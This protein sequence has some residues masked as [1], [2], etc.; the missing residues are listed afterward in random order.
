MCLHFESW[1]K[2]IDVSPSQTR[3]CYEILSQKHPR[4]TRT[5]G[6]VHCVLVNVVTLSGS[7]I[8][9]ETHLWTNVWGIT[10]V[11]YI[12]LSEMGIPMLTVGISIP[13]AMRRNVCGHLWTE[14]AIMWHEVHQSCFV[15][16]IPV[17]PTAVFII[18][19][20][21]RKNKARFY[22]SKLSTYRLFP[23]WGR[24][25]PL[26]SVLLEQEQLASSV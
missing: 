10:D 23:V 17:K 9:K 20:F 21:I 3:L 15:C 8:T 22:F 4:E 12:K 19:P 11:I 6:S 16:H 13:W 1:D 7:W 14:W 25:F 24:I 2:R 26:L 18:L 5:T